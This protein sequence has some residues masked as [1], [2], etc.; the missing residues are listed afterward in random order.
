MSAKAAMEGNA[1][2]ISP[3][4][5][6]HDLAVQKHVLAPGELR[7]ESR[8]ELEQRRD[9]PLRHDASVSRRQDSADDLEQRALAAAI[10]TNQPQHFAALRLKADI[11]KRPEIRMHP[12]G[13]NGRISR[14]RSAGRSIQAIE[15]GNVLN[16]N[17]G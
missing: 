11:A 16:K 8:A 17:H 12:V 10:G 1:R 2:S 6:S 13:K 5:Q 15:L 7:I 9:P 14:I 3:P 4:A